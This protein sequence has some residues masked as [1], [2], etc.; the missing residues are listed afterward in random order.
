MIP[1]FESQGRQ[2]GP[3]RVGL[4]ASERCLFV[5]MHRSAHTILLILITLLL[6]FGVT[7][8]YSTS[9]SV[10][11]ET[12]LARQ[13][14]W[15]GL[16]SVGALVLRY[17]D[18]RQVVRKSGFCLSLLGVALLYLT[19]VSVIHKFVPGADGWINRLPLISG[20]VKGSFR[21]L[22]L[23]PF[24]IQPSEFA[25][26]GI[27]VY[28]AD[29][30]HRHARHVQEFWRGFLRPMMVVGL[31]TLL[32][33]LG[34]DLSSTVVTGA[35][36]FCLAFVGGVPMRYLVLIVVMGVVVFLGAVKAS[37]ERVSRLTSYRN[38]EQ[39][40]QTEGYQLW[41]SQLA[42][43]SGGW[44]G[45]GF[46]GSRMKQ[47]YLPE[48]HTDFIVAI[49]GEELG[50]IG[51]GS[52][53]LLYLAIIGTLFAIGFQAPDRAGMMLASGVALSVGL[54]ALVNISVV[55]GFFPTTGVTAPFVSYGGSSMLVSLLGIGLMLSVSRNS[56][57][58]AHPESQHSVPPMS[59][60]RLFRP[61]AGKR[62]AK[63]V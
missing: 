38:P 62:P 3:N 52:L 61:Q 6:F 56:G 27:I 14:T 8:L 29:Y 18:Y 58:D 4:V 45:V 51:V 55:S 40:Q 59:Y 34:K 19:L 10:F 25:R 22:R 54:Q 9:Y 63:T 57:K 32:V 39:L 5:R 12:K 41:A 16:G 15:I 44:T 31:V 37:P 11:G 21:W 35:I 26:L 36:V 13:L 48:A 42:L 17:L 53:I 28:L 60:G 47:R 33:L 50:Y 49:V 23:G 20:P 1:E 43:G 2:R 30:Y 7:M 24:S 46:T